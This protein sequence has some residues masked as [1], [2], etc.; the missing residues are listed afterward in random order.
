[1]LDTIFFDLDNTLL[2]FTRAEAEALR[3]ALAEEDIPAH[4]AVLQRYHVINIAQWELLEE[5][6][7]TRDEVLVRR[8]DLL[9]EELGLERSAEAVCARYEEYLKEGRWLLPG[10]LEL[11]AEL[12][13]RYGLYAASNGSA[14]VQNSRLD[15]SGLR[16]WFRGIFISE[17]V[18]FDKPSPDF[19]EACFQRIPD[20]SRDSALI[21]GDSLTSDIRGGRNAGLRT[22]WFN[23]ERSPRRAD[24]LPDYE[25]ASLEELP[26]LL[27]AL[28]KKSFR[29]AEQL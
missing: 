1:M 15:A 5:G 9:F 26:G 6:K 16:S 29:Q 4:D 11:L 2:D 12:A 28:S 24:I 3:R 14:A 22:C 10:A 7:L 8:F 19:F 18:G 25:I 17:E 20:F 13:P 27:A 23:P 21:V